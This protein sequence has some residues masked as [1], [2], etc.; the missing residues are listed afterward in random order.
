M[1]PTRGPVAR[2][3][4]AV[5]A[6]SGANQ[7]AFYVSAGEAFVDY[8]L[9]SEFISNRA[10]L[11]FSGEETFEGPVT[12]VDVDSEA[13]VGDGSYVWKAGSGAIADHIYSW[14]VEGATIYDYEIPAT[15]RA[16]TP[17]L[18]DGFL[19]WLEWP[20]AY[21]ATVSVV[22]K[23]SRCDLTT[24]LATVHTFSLDER[25][26]NA[27]GAKVPL[28][29]P[30]DGSLW[31]L[32]QMS[33]EDGEEW[34]RAFSKDYTTGNAVDVTGDVLETQLGATMDDDWAQQDPNTGQ[35]DFGPGAAVYYPSEGKAYVAWQPTPDWP[36]PSTVNWPKLWSMDSITAMVEVWTS[37]G[38]DHEPAG[39][40]CLTRRGAFGQVHQ[41]AGDPF[42][43]FRHPVPDLGGFPEVAFSVDA[44]AV[45]YIS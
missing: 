18:R 19:W 13:T 12:R 17:L 10:T 6:A 36:G 43:I 28:I 41:R 33:N 8:Y 24:D 27:G 22:L 15:K 42:N 26:G 35:A 5:V 14:D 32:W 4:L 40:A 38:V 20:I 3:L 39:F 45:F 30:L 44:R 2:D 37:S 31:F 21:A 29:V 11:S 9:D 7:E 23:K 34:Y 25:N 16:T 1:S